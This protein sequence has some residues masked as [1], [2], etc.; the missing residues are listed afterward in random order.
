MRDSVIGKMTDI[1]FCFQ[2]KYLAVVF[3]FIY[4]V[5]KTTKETEEK[6]WENVLNG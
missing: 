3:E 6:H 1:H 4:S 2:K 5:A